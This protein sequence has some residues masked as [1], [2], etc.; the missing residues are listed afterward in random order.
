MINAMQE[1]YQE[2]FTDLNNVL[3]VSKELKEKDEE[4]KGNENN[5][6]EKYEINS[7]FEDLLNQ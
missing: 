1:K 4:K 3:S 7:G 2:C 6:K 5:D